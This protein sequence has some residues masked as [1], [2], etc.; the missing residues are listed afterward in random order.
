MPKVSRYNLKKEDL[1]RY[2]NDLE[3]SFA[4]F[5]SRQ[6]VQEFLKDLLTHTE[7]KML[8]KRLQIAKLL[9]DG[10]NYDF[11][12]ENL[13]VTPGTI[14]QVSNILA[15]AGTGYKKVWDKLKRVNK[16]RQKVAA[17]RINRLQRY[18]RRPLSRINLI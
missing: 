13:K 9:L 18:V 15:N 11:I 7:K 2:F 14:A 3:L 10:E 5:D 16:S 12:R 1:F 4:L 6:E 17:D 8:A